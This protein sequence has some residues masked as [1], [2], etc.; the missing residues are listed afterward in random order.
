MLKSVKYKGALLILLAIL[1]CG[2]AKAEHVE[3]EVT[4]TAAPDITEDA[5]KIVISEVMAKNRAV[6]QDENGSFSDWI[7]LENVSGE[8]V[9][10]S[11]W[12]I[13]DDEN[14]TAWA[15]PGVIMPAG[16]KLIVF[17]DG[18][19]SAGEYLHTDFSLSQGETVCLF[20]KYNYLAASAY[21]ETAE[22]DVSLALGADGQYSLSLYPTPLYENSSA[23]YDAWQASLAPRGPL[24]I[25]EVVTS[26]FSSAYAE[27][28]GYSDWVE[29]R[30][31]SDSAVELSD[32]YLSDD[33]EDYRLWSFGSGSLAPGESLLVFCDDSDVPTSSKN[34]RTHFS[35][36]GEQEE[37]FLF[38][39]SEGLVDFAS[40]RD[41]PYNCSYGRQDGENGWFF[42]EEQTPLKD[43]GAGYRRVSAAP[44]ALYAD[45]VF[46]DVTSV[47]VGFTAVG[48]IYYTD[49]CSVPTAASAK[50]EAEFAVSET[51]VVRAISVEEGAMPSRPTTLSFIVNEGHSLPVLSLVSND[52]DEFNWMY[53]G[54]VKNF[55]TPGSLSLYEDDGSFTI[56]CGVKMH[57][58]TSLILPKKNM[59]VRF[60]AAYGD[61]VLEYDAFDGGVGEFTNLV[62]RAGQ[63]FYSAI[64]R[65]ELCTNLALS[66]SDNIVSQRSKYCVLYVNGSYSGIYALMEKTNEQHYANLAGVSRE[67]V[68]VEEAAIDP[69]SDLYRDVFEFCMKNDMSLPENYEYFCSLVD[70]DSLI[71]WTL[72]EGFCGNEDLSFGN[73]RY[74]RSTEN[75]GK[76]RFVFYDLDSTFHHPDHN[77][78]NIYSYFWLHNRQV[79]LILEPLTKNEAFVDRLM[80]RAAELFEGPLSN[81]AVL[82]EI[83]RLAD[84]IRPE[85]ARDYARFGMTADKWEWN[86]EWIKDFINYYDW[87]ELSE[88]NLCQLFKL[89]DEERAHYFG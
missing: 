24:V 86:I 58:E 38:S 54:R 10:L 31:I 4:P 70:I 72:I 3:V 19:D 80:T 69:S 20:N 78:H 22:A 27:R 79:S 29:I 6:L 75:D 50:Y 32:W 68:T 33:E 2:C 28:L 46:D 83:D 39:E 73:L 57:G 45:G 74:C 71:D 36:D 30:N 37:L 47:P 56:P 55:E 42:F 5:E 63:D 51:S 14:K 77:Y 9:N 35:L 40:L 18:K 26:N 12:S 65:N 87:A 62:L 1:L 52:K 88:H 44:Q 8:D 43:N 25:N 60:R 61:P 17:A 48:E 59:S 7:E 66:A 82:A 41:I 21:C 64:I 16:S 89:S 11:G 81:E 85:V 67:S 76:W 23:G 15:F 53:H 49:D 13:S 84:E 34:L